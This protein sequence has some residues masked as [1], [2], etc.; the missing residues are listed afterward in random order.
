MVIPCYKSSDTLEPL[1]ERIHASLEARGVDYEV[2]LVVDG[3]P[4][5][6]WDVVR[7]LAKD[8]R[9][10]GIELMRNYGQHNALLAGI[11]SAEHDLIVTMDDDL[12]HP[13][14]QIPRLLDALG[15][16]IDLVYGVAKVEEHGF[17]RN[18]ASRA[19]K[20]AMAIT[21]GVDHARQISAFR[22]FRSDLR[23][24]FLNVEDAFVSI[25][26]ILSWVTTRIASIE[27]EMER[28]AEAESN[29][30][31]RALFRHA[32]N[33]VTGYSITPLKLVTML[34][35]VTALVGFL[36]LVV[37]LV[38]YFTGSTEVAGFT[39]LASMVALFA[40][41]QMAAIGILGEYLG[42][43]HFRSMHR[44]TF[45]IRDEIE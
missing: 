39:T 21:L 30:N 28:R 10:R 43:L 12:Q 19:V 20:S 45:V 6:T 22:A 44:P 7:R 3:S 36:A 8:D 41:A 32:L 1:V 16:D 13:P 9:V 4:D 14:E 33:M 42:R 27:V 17:W 26:V 18:L 34:G 29:Y 23:S 40:G 38:L 35:L 2:V 5:D 37:V 15:D 31:V 25:D 24:P 11:Q